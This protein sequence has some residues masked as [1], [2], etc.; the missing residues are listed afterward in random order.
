MQPIRPYDDRHYHYG[1]DSDDGMPPSEF[2]DDEVA[3]QRIMPST[4]ILLF[5]GPL[6]SNP[7]MGPIE[8]SQ[9]ID[10]LRNNIQITRPSEP[11]SPSTRFPRAA[12]GR[13]AYMWMH[14]P[15]VN[16]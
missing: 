13:P 8:A 14:H 12:H 5:N 7:P 2:I 16:Y 1:N 4:G 15:P 10:S 9:Y 11:S 3:S 6:T